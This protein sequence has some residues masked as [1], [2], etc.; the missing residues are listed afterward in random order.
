MRHLSLTIV[1]SLFTLL[2]WASSVKANLDELDRVVSQRSLYDIPKHKEIAG[3]KRTYATVTNDS[4]RYNVL[5]ALYKEYRTFRIDSAIIVADERLKIARRM[6]IPSKVASATLNLAE[7]YVKSGLPDK[8]LAMLDTLERTTLEDYH[9][10]Y[11]N[12][13]YRAAYKLKTQTEMLPSDRK[14]AADKVMELRDMA[15]R[16]SAPDSRGFYTI[17]AEKLMDA[18]L[19][20]EAVEKIEEA[21]SLFDFSNDAAMQYTMGEIYLAAGK[22]EEAMKSLS[23]AAILDLSSATKEY[24]S[25]ILLASLLFEQGDVE[26][27]FVYINCALE[28][29]HFSN[30][31]LRN[32]AIMENMP[33]IDKAFHA[34]E[35]KN[36]RLTHIFL[37]SG[38]AMLALLLVTLILLLKTLRKNRKMLSTIEEINAQLKLRNKQLEDAD[39][40]K[41]KHINT[42][43]MSNARYIARL[44]DYRKTVYRLMKTGQY[45]K[46]L[47]ALKSDRN[48]SKDINAFH[49]MFDE[50]FLSMFPD[51]IDSVNSLLNEPLEL[52]DGCR[53]TPELRVIALMRLG[54]SSTEEIAGILHYSPQ[55]VYNL[56]SS[57][58][59]MSR[60]PRED[61]DRAISKL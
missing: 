15:L 44:K 42:L 59:S 37:W 48:N 17:Q 51:F 55:S 3:L 2:S 31:N 61:F 39:K 40:L 23:R 33:V 25:L 41:L 1:F 24:Q 22:K 14:A 26:R 58:R 7:S 16:E 11:L 5:R 30:A 46:A 36:K 28:D 47:E 45:D 54:L 13:V 21:D 38:G 60:L 6:G 4:D 49:E 34:Y 29:T 56:R 27:A 18:G 12:S 52:K 10:K 43:I 20:A 9:Q 19:F 32:P 57:I 8:A 50:A 53:L 35:T